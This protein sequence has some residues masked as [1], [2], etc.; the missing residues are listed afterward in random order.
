MSI[1]IVADDTRAAVLQ[2][3]DLDNALAV[4]RE[5]VAGWGWEVWVETY[6]EEAD[7]GTLNKFRVVMGPAVST[8]PS[9]YFIRFYGGPTDV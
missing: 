6:P 4:C 7:D 2:R 9:F 3:D 8:N 5:A 1:K